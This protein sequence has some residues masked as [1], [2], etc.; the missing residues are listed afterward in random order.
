MY[1][2]HC[3]IRCNTATL[4]L[5]FC[6]S[7]S[8]IISSSLDT[9]LRNSILLVKCLEQTLSKWQKLVKPIFKEFEA[10][11]QFKSDFLTHIFLIELSFRFFVFRNSSWFIS[12]FYHSIH[13]KNIY[14]FKTSRKNMTRHITLMK[15][16]NKP[17]YL[18]F[19]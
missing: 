13:L 17:F 9:P 14:I 18:N 19:R 15:N 11:Q 12:R 4:F 3:N 2:L 6:F 10:T 7:I 1:W 8:L 16:R 5:R